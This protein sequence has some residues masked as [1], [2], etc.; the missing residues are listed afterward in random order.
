MDGGCCNFARVGDSA[1]GA[2]NDQGTIERSSTWPAE[3]QPATRPSWHPRSGCCCRGPP[4]GRSHELADDPGGCRASRA[5]ATFDERFGRQQPERASAGRPSSARAF[6]PRCR[7]RVYACPAT[8][9]TPCPPLQLRARGRD[10]HQLVRHRQRHPNSGHRSRGM[11]L[12]SAQV[13]ST[14]LVATPTA[15]ASRARHRVVIDV[16]CATSSAVR[17]ERACRCCDRHRCRTRRWSP[18]RG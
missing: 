18:G 10:P 1:G 5:T 16:L 17:P 8:D 9:R 4:Y 15:T 12:A 2:Q 14:S 3:S 7:C 11:G 13:R 6:H